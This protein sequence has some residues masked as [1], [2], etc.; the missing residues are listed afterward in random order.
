MKVLF[1]YYVPSGGVETLNRQRCRALRLA[2]IEAHCLYYAW[3]AGMQN[4]ADYPIYVTKNDIEI[5]HVLDLHQYD[6]I[7]V[8]TDHAS[9]ARFRMLGFKGKMILEIQGYGPKH[10]ALAQLREAAPYINRYAAGL[11]NPNTPHIAVLFQELYPHKPQFNFNNCFDSQQFTYQCHQPPSSPVIAW[12]GRIEDNKNWR[13]FLQIGHRLREH[14]P[15]LQMWMF[16]DIQLSQPQE[17]EQF[18]TMIEELELSSVLTIRSNIPNAD[19]PYYYSVIGDSGGLL[20]CTSKVEGAPYAVLE[21]MSC[22]CPVLTTNSDGVSTSVYHDATG[23]FY[24]LGDIQHA[25][26]E[27]LDMM[28]NHKQREI[29]RNTAKHHVEQN[30]NPHTYAMN[31]VGMLQNI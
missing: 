4:A 11:L 5:K 24:V 2:G 8:T 27:A 28:F 10:V 30:F 13:E 26:N 18:Y 7:V 1:V 3:G 19:M 17:R 15:G 14:V 31:F 9:F 20:C 29:I 23:K 25:V 22:R 6:V 16:E 12:L 21:A